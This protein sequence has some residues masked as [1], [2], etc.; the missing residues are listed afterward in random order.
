MRRADRTEHFRACHV[1][2]SAGCESGVGDDRLGLRGG[3]YEDR[4]DDAPLG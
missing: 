1:T 4:L 2:E 3:R